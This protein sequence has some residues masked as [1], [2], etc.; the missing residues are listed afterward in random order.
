MVKVKICGVTNFDDALLVANLG[1]DFIGFNFWPESPRKVSVKNAREMALKMPPFVS[2]VGVFV[3]ELS[4][5]VVKTAKKAGLKYI[6]LHGSETPEYC[7]AVKEAAGLPVIKAFRVS[8]EKSLESI[9]AYLDAIDYLLLDAFVEGEP[10]GTGQTFN[11]DTAVKAK[12]LG[13]P[14]I[15][16]GGLTP[17]NVTEA[18]LKVAPFAVDVASGVERLQRRKDYD[19]MNKFIRAARGL[20]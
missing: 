4:E 20:K 2:P 6:Q 7:K 5:E 15:L 18:I 3:N 17:E 9:P 13:K 11:W 19:K 14:V 8:D 16:A 12:E 1:S 10:G